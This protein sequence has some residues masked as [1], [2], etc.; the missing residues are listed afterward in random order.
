MI[1]LSV[2]DLETWRYWREQDDSTVPELLR[3]LRHEEPPTPQMGAGRAFARAF[4]EATESEWDRIAVDGWTFTFQGSLAINVCALRELK[5]EQVFKTPS[6]PVTLVGKV[7]GVDG[8]VVRDQKLTERWDPERYLDSLQWRSYLT[9]LGGTK[10]VYDVFVGRYDS[11]GAQE[12]TV[13]EY[14]PLAFFAYPG[15]DRHVQTAVNELA[16]VVYRFLPERAA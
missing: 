15:M 10:F 8:I 2:T 5:V 1:R 3:R 6:G 14:H 12:V 11:R 16:D 4:E 9:M 13:T 7:D